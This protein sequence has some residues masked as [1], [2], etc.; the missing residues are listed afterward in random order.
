MTIMIK[1]NRIKGINYLRSHG[2][3]S[4]CDLLVR[5]LKILSI[6]DARKQVITVNVTESKGRRRHPISNKALLSLFIFLI[7]VEI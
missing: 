6:A 3:S 5:N 2:A 4:S 7:K 1:Y